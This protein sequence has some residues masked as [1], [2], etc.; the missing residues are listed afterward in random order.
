MSSILWKSA[1]ACAI[2][3]LVL[4]G[5]GPSST[6]ETDRAAATTATTATAATTAVPATATT[7]PA[8][9]AAPLPGDNVTTPRYRIAIHYPT[10]SAQE[11]VLAQALRGTSAAAKRGFMQALPDP[12]QFPEFA[13]R[14]LQLQLDY[15]VAARTADF[16]SVRERGM[17]DTGGAHPIPVEGSFVYDV[18]AQRV[19]ALDDL[20][21]DPATA[22]QRLST[23]ARNALSEKLLAKA[24][25]ASEASPEARREWTGNMRQ[26][27]DAGTDP[28]AA[29]FSN[30]VVRAGAGDTAAGLTLIFS[31]YQVAPYVYGTQTVD[32]PA[33]VFAGLLKPPYRQAFAD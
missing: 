28:T 3:A 4:A 32:V 24:P 7:A 19:I 11:A 2:V 25:D 14:Q 16:T 17:S 22:R 12:K 18:H 29:N 26:M 5:C 1:A 9:S 8:A 6:P 15:T 33:E 31:P 30:F 13:D 10:L 21:T 27:I 23:L 20:F